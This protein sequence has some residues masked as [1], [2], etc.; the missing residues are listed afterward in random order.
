M[1]CLHPLSVSS[2]WFSSRTPLYTPA[3]FKC[4]W[5]LK[6]KCGWRGCESGGRCLWQQ[7]SISM[8]LFS[9]CSFR[10]NVSCEYSSLDAYGRGDCHQF[11]SWHLN[12]LLQICV[13]EMQINRICPDKLK[14]M[15]SKHFWSHNF[16]SFFVIRDLHCQMFFYLRRQ[17]QTDNAS[18]SKPA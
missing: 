2:V 13:F 7:S 17:R 6:Y 14:N 4:T 5:I 16:L 15:V 11:A 12:H 8:C 18:Q 3:I 9:C 1:R 10:F